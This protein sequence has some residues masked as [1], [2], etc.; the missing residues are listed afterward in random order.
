MSPQL[1]ADS[2]P[3]DLRAGVLDLRVPE[4]RSVNKI[5]AGSTDHCEDGYGRDDPG[6]RAQ[7]G[8]VADVCLVLHGKAPGLLRTRGN[9]TLSLGWKG[10]F[11]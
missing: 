11:L 1:Y 2:G 9:Y 4:A 6:D 3:I 10:G 7:I 5:R 8:F